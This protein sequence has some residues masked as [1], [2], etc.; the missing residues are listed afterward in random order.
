M[1]VVRL[2]LRLMLSLEVSV[3]GFGTDGGFM[4][5]CLVGEFTALCGA[6]MLE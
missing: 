1:I 5:L 3:M 2:V 4:A 6:I